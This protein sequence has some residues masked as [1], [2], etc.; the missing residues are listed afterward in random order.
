MSIYENCVKYPKT[1]H[2]PSSPGLQNDDRVILTLDHLLGQEVIITK[3]M[4]GENTTLYADNFHARSLDGRHHPSR[5]WIKGFWGGIRYMIPAD[6]RICGENMYAEH[7]IRYDDLSTYFYGFSIWNKIV[8]S[9]FCYDWDATINFFERFG[10]TPVPTLYRGIFTEKVVD[11]LANR[12]DPEKDEGF[13]V[14]V[15]R[16]FE[17]R[18]FQSV[19]AKY[20]RKGHV[21]TDEHWMTKAVVPNGLKDK[22]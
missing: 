7:S 8:D 16:A 5:D 9:D 19:V 1:M 18:E 22:A 12:L 3:K 17:M 14:R 13:V 21:Q 6:L 2:L 4:D 10:I 15:T 20:V 11:N